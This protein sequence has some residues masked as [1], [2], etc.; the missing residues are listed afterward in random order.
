MGAITYCANVH[1]VAC[2]DDVLRHLRGESLDISRRVKSQ[3]PF[4]LGLWIPRGAIDEAFTRIDEIK[5]C[6]DAGAMELASFNAFPMDVFHGRAVKADV[7][8]P[9]WADGERSSYTRSIARLGAELGAPDFSIST[10]SGGF[11]PN[12]SGPKAQ[13]YIE[14][15]LQW[16]RFGRQLEDE[17]GARVALALEPEPFNTLED[18]SDALELWDRLDRH[19]NDLSRDD[20]HRYLGLCFDTC[21]FSVRFRDPLTSYRALGEVPV[22]KI[23]VSVAPRHREDG[24]GEG[25]E[26]FTGLAEPVYLH[27]TYHRD[28]AGRIHAHLDLDQVKRAPGEWRTHFHV[29]IHWGERDDT[30]GHELVPFLKALGPDRPLLEVETYSFSV[31]K[32]TKASDLVTSITEE[33]AWCQKHSD[34]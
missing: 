32:G 27:Q 9:D 23:Q 7:Y 33:I 2:F 26:A 10:V 24:S 4:P 12:D 13:A 18:E 30:T 5:S 6:L 28:L 29:P 21:H 8:R 1:P 34:P 19:R 16:V 20:L 14:A 11:R 22:H 3:G 25:W 31:L 17:R 15:F